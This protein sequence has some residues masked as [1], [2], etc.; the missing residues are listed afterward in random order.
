MAWSSAGVP[1]ADLALAAADKPILAGTPD[2][3]DLTGGWDVGTLTGTVA[4]ATDEDANRPARRVGDGLPG[5]QTTTNA[6]GTQFS[7]VLQFAVG[8][9]FD[10]I[11][12]LN[13][14]LETLNCTS[15]TTEVA[16]DAAF[17]TNLQT[18]STLNPSLEASDRRIAD[19]EL[20]HLGGSALR[21]S[22]VEYI[23]IAITC[24]SGF[25]EIG[26]VVLGRR[27]QLK[28]EPNRPWDPDQ[29][30]SSLDRFESRAGV[31]TDTPRFRGRRL[32][33]A[34]LNPDETDKKQDLIDWWA[35]INQGAL[36][37]VWIDK[38]NSLPSDFYFMKVPAQDPTFDFPFVLPF[39]REF[40]LRGVE[41][42][43]TFFSQ[44]P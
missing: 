3:D 13:H 44:D 1:A 42:G 11:G 2:P 35:D 41:Q 31:I 37:F 33:A 5:L 9:E 32:I 7:L 30:V 22:N 36:P 34:N 29:N 10:F 40:T 16:D 26:Q 19:L 43:P 25:P 17:T 24:N 12:F 18:I 27:Y 4:S 23:R 28:H 15:L 14:N 21:Y 38:P 8:I 20:T 39:V 6:S